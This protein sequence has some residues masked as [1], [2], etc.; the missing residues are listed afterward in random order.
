MDRAVLARAGGILLFF[1]VLPHPW[2]IGLASVGFLA[3][4]CGWIYSIQRRRYREA[5]VVAARLW[6]GDFIQ[7][8]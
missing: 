1:L 4:L 2:W 7:P 3:G 5:A 6:S 8:S